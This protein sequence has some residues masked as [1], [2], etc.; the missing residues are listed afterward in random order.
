MPLNQA[1]G[2]LLASLGRA[3]KRG[4]GQR[5][6]YVGAERSL[7]H[8][9]GDQG[10]GRSV[11]SPACRAFVTVRDVAFAKVLSPAATARLGWKARKAPSVLVFGA[12]VLCVA[13]GDN[14]VFPTTVDPGQDF[15][16]ADVAYDANYYYCK[17]EPMLFSQRCGPGDPSRGDAPGGCHFNVTSFRLTNYSPLVEK[18]CKGIVP[19]ANP[20]TA[21]ERNYQAA[22]AKMD[23]NPDQAPLLNRPTGKV[24]HPRV[25]FNKSSPQADIIRQ[26]ATKYSSQ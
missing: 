5:L 25:I 14:G 24:A 7:S 8:R 17:V 20:P 11:C 1:A 19:T 22:Q 10:R 2:Q 3:F 13:C 15:Q 6:I 18:S 23:R 26:W 4:R 16:I 21:A 9:T 12:A